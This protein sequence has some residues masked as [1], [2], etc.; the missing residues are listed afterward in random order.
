MAGRKSARALATFLLLAA[1]SS[2]SRRYEPTWAS[3]DTRPLP[4]WWADAKIGIFVHFSLFSVPSFHGEWFIYDWL[5]ARDPDVVAFMQAT[6]KPGFAYANYASRF[7]AEL[8]NA[9]EWLEL[10]KASGARY[11]VPT[12]KHHDAFAMWPSPYSPNFNA[13][14][15]G[16]KQDII[17]ALANATRAAGLKFGAYH[18]LFE[19]YNPLYL[20]DKANNWTTDAFVATKTGPE[21]YDLVCVSLRGSTPGS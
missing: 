7:T 16:P 13:Q 8:F 21:L 2:E 4:Q 14:D 10:F 5:T 20:R 3:L 9:T 6:E 15:V 17:G 11:V 18:S 12:L 1:A 19:F